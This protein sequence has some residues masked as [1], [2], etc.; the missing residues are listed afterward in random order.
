MSPWWWGQCHPWWLDRC[1][2][3]QHQL[4]ACTRRGKGPQFP[5]MARHGKSEYI[6]ASYFSVLLTHGFCLHRHGR[7][8][9]SCART[10]KNG[11]I[12]CTWARGMPRSPCVYNG[13][14]IYRVHPR[15]AYGICLPARYLMVVF[16]GNCGF[17]MHAWDCHLCFWFER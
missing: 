6:M 5:P 11:S 8:L 13:C 1:V 2:T 14:S 10:A 4:Q 9:R 15:F 16:P 3:V 7:I 17:N 12:F